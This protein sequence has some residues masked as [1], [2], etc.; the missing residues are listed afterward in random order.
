MVSWSF[1]TMPELKIFFGRM[2]FLLLAGDHL[3][4]PP[5]PKS[6]SLLAPL[7]GTALEHQAGAATFFQS[8]GCLFHGNSH[9]ISRSDSA[10]NPPQNEDSWG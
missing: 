2:S 4:L 1:A 9:E 8:L 7:E 10:R 5:V 6:S 3:Q